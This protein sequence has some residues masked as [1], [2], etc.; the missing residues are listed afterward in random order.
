M[1][2]I[3]HLL[4]TV[5]LS[6]ANVLVAEEA[7]KPARRVDFNREIRPILSNHC[8]QCHGPDAGQRK[9]G[10]RLDVASSALSTAES[11]ATAIVPGKPA[12][13]ELVARIRHDDESLRMPPAETKKPLSDAQKKLIETWIEQGGDFQMHWAF[14]P[15][16]RPA[17]G[18][19]G[20]SR[21]PRQELDLLVLD[22]LRKADLAPT[23]EASREMLARR[24]AL[25]L[26]GLPPAPDEVA[27]FV[28]EP[29]PDAVERWVDRLLGQPAFGER[30][31]VDW[32][33]AS[34]FADTH[35]Y[36]IDSGRD[37]SRWREYVIDSFNANQPFDR[38][39]TEQLAGDLLPADGDPRET[40]RRQ[41]ASGFSRNN[42]INF[43]GG[44]IP[45][46]YLNAYLVDR[47]NTLGTVFLGLSVACTQCHDHKYDP[48]T[49]RD[50]YQLY[51]FFN[52][53]PENG[54]DG[55]KGNAVP[56]LK[57]PTEWEET[58]L[59][60]LATRI[61]DLEKRLGGPLPEV[62]AEQ[63]RWETT[64][65]D[66]SRSLWRIAEPKEYRSVGGATLKLESDRSVVA[67]GKNPDRETYEVSWPSTSPVA[68]IRLEALPDPSFPASG[69]GRS[70]NGNIV[71][72]KVRVHV[73]QSASAPWM[74]TKIAAAD[75]DFSQ[76][77]Y[78]IAG[79]IDDDAKSGWG[80]FPE[81]GKPHL[82][83]FRLAEPIA[84]SS[85]TELKVTLEFQSEFAGHQI[86]RFRL[87]TSDQ[88]AA[89]LMDSLPPEVTIALGVARD[90]RTEAQAKQ[91]RD[92]YRQHVSPR[93]RELSD[94]LAEDRRRRD[95][96]DKRIPTVM[97][98]QEME[99]PRETF[100]LMRG[101]YDKPG[102]PVGANVP[103]FLP[104]LAEG[105]PRNRLG[106]AQW[107]TQPDHPLVSRVAV[108]RYWQLFFG[109][110][111]VKTVEDFGSQGE[112]PSHPVLLDWLAT[113]FVNADR[114]ELPQWDLKRLIARIVTSATYRQSSAAT[115]ERVARD[116]E[117]R[118]LARGP[119]FRLQ[120]E[121]IRDMALASSGLLDRRLGGASVFP[122]Q[123]Q[124]LWEELMSRAD[125]KN[126][127]AQEYEQSHGG[128]LYRRTMYTFWKRTCPP[129]N[130]ATFDAPDRETCTVRRA[131]T[132][133]PLQ[134]LVLM[135][136]PTYAEAARK[137]AERIMREG[138]ATTAERTT[139]AFRTVLARTP[140][141][142]ELTILERLHQR[143]LA[144]FK[145]DPASAA[146]LLEVGESSR[147]MN[148][149]T[150][151]LATW[152]IIASAILNLDEAIAKG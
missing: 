137:F 55:S 108:N 53:I 130:L 92:Y 60:T 81:A 99:K 84:P 135:N 65:L 2:A 40:L 96:L 37:M 87:A 110:G 74:E 19:A 79:A 113:D 111:I 64:A 58:E 63:Q 34:R 48:M 70:T 50:F 73:R 39:T 30:L 69:P 125:G 93:V 143:Q 20:G 46:E 88:R 33:D 4:L 101:Q 114:P 67:S 35:G 152:T 43:E 90:Q 47:V 119:R 148:L 12:A 104:P 121:F 107:L 17:L 54:L 134:A 140:T 62:D 141:T 28:A 5:T 94:Q 86:G 80:V 26:T 116:P 29:S 11:G 100:V 150:T 117:N 91:L 24:L 109:T 128:D 16:K 123:P 72:T 22:S 8:Y 7:G 89:P 105:A 44:A 23:D 41:I 136:D 38:F 15:P 133:T 131:R 77:G 61:A 59:A 25:D 68:S 85:T 31:A 66:S 56:L 129:A 146:R 36:H 103:A 49:T 42:M 115:S 6:S 124:G 78:A 126:W 76:Q 97:V 10:L 120:A 32:L 1:V 18:D 52:S 138:G 21:W 142:A 145:S 3:L 132:N 75:A 102:D 27:R 71:M 118:L 149:D 151:E 127:T 14:V 106:L 144:K 122:Y 51:A 139:F 95:A 45:Q 98:M 13:S 112:A 82:A 147:D 83:A 57:A 9:G